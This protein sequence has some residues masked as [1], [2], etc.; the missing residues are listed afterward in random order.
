MTES[1]FDLRDAKAQDPSFIER[2]V[3]A[4]ANWLPD[5]QLTLEQMRSEPDL[6]HYVGGWQRASDTGVVA[7]DRAESPVGAVW[8]RQFLP[9]DQGYGYVEADVP[10]LSIG[11]LDHWRGQGVGRSLMRAQADQARTRGLHRISLSV[12][13]A[14]PAV[15]LYLSEGWRVVKSGRHSDTMVL[16]LARG[17]LPLG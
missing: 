6:R 5:R 4:D 10:E 8:L 1:A 15:N 2:M 3:L 17:R 13:R 16:E 12:E 11:V 7:V 9:D 14:N